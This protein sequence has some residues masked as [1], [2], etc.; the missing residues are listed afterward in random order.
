[1]AEWLCQ[2]SQV[3]PCRCCARVRRR[4][5]RIFP[6]RLQLCRPASS[7]PCQRVWARSHSACVV[8]SEVCRAASQRKVHAAHTAAA[9]RLH[10]CSPHN[11]HLCRARFTLLCSAVHILRAFE[12]ERH[13]RQQEAASI[14]GLSELACCLDCIR[15]VMQG[16]TCDRAATQELRTC[17]TGRCK[18]IDHRFICVCE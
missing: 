7:L 5:C 11:D 14:V 15:H 3:V 6:S 2:R 10:S 16:R 1:M 13:V 17:H 4:A 12:C 18:G 9:G 8:A